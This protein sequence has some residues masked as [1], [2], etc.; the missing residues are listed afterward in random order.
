MRKVCC[1]A[2]TAEGRTLPERQP[3]LRLAGTMDVA[4][5]GAMA[6]GVLEDL[7]SGQIDAV[8]AAHL[9]LRS[10]PAADP[11]RLAR[12]FEA[13]ETHCRTALHGLGWEDSA[14]SQAFWHHRIR[15][16]HNGARTV[17]QTLH[18]EVPR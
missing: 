6:A 9:D 17:A 16:C 14:A 8:L 5:R 4:F 3:G 1:V 10:L 18:R 2:V 13:A 12:L 15:M 7:D 11:D